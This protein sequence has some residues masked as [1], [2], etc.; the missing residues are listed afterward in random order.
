VLNNNC[1]N[2]PGRHLCNE[3]G[4]HC[5]IQRDGYYIMNV[6]CVALGA[7]S[8][9]YYILPTVKRLQGEYRYIY[10]IVR[11]GT[12]VSLSFTHERVEGQ[13]TELV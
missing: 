5:I 11:T 1:V 9:I 10:V 7:F 3:L 12:D 13:D 8:L 2:D 6:V 4:G